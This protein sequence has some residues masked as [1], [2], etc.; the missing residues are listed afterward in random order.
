M[1]TAVSRSRLFIRGRWVGL[2]VLLCGAMGAVGAAV[3]AGHAPRWSANSRD[4]QRIVV[5]PFVGE[6]TAPS[7]SGRSLAESVATRLRSTG[8]AD[9]R[10]ARYM[11]AGADYLLD[12][13]VHAD[14]AGVEVALRLRANG[15]RNA[16]WTATFWRHTA[17][18]ALPAD[19][20][21]AVVDALGLRRAE[22]TKS[23]PSP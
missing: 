3:Y 5:E 19:L 13:R 17:D 15:R 8:V 18:P 16:M 23:P 12:G 7:W 21:A 9:S 20:A 2:A 11:T 6:N 22:P 14:S 4:V 1:E 10:V